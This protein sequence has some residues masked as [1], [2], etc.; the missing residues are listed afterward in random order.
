MKKNL[1]DWSLMA[2]LAALAFLLLEPFKEYLQSPYVYITLSALFIAFTLD[3]IQNFFY[4][5]YPFN[6]NF[7]LVF[8]KISVILTL[9]ANTVSSYQMKIMTDT[10]KVHWELTLQNSKN[11]KELEAEVQRLKNSLSQLIK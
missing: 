10:S 2:I 9:L 3:Y 1:L 11:I 8:F 4:K 5:E 7:V 6:K